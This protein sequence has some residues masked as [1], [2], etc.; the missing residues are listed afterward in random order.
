MIPSA[1]VAITGSPHF[2]RQ[3]V[4][5][6]RGLGWRVDYVDPPGRRPSR[7]L[8][9]LKPVAT[10]D[11]LYLCTGQIGRWSRPW[12]AK[13]VL[14]KRMVQHWV[15][16]DVL[17]AREVAKQGQVSS[18]LRDQ[19]V[20]WA[21]APWIAEE[22]AEFNVRAK[23]VPFPQLYLPEKV[24]PLPAEFAVLVYLSPVKPEIYG[25]S[26]TVRLAR[27]LPSVP[28]LVVGMDGLPDAPP[29]MRFLG[30]V[31]D[32]LP[33]YAQ[34]SVL[35]RFSQHDG[36]PRM[37]L[38]ALAC[39]RHVVWSYYLPTVHAVRSYDE[40]RAQVEELYAQHRRGK[41]ASNEEGA[42]YAWQEFSPQATLQRFC[43]EMI[44]ALDT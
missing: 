7:W 22:A 28:F 40:L 12:L 18:A 8:N 36:M 27:E 24:L 41:L 4:A 2:T 30:W 33:I 17:Y 9:A 38:E 35:V 44:A 20:H 3:L 31:Q 23:L 43:D 13:T 14:N 37:V 34:S 5:V 6:L 32:M 1:R 25:A 42:R 26:E 10:A 29:N 15:G 16:S 19:C 21:I 39:G 11:L